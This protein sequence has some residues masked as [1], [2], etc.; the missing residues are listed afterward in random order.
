MSWA[1]LVWISLVVSFLPID[2]HACGVWR[3]LPH[4]ALRMLPLC[5]EPAVERQIGQ[6]CIRHE[7]LCGQT[8][9]KAWFDRWMAELDDLVTAQKLLGQMVFS[10]VQQDTAWAVFWAPTQ[11]SEEGFVILVSRMRAA[12]LEEK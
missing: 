4:N 9:F 7:W 11:E 1:A 3:A 5:D 10:G 6:A 2:A 8:T 12:P